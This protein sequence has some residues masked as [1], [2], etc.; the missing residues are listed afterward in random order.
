[1]VRCKA[2]TATGKQCSR[3]AA[4]G[5]F[6]KQH[7]KST[8]FS[9]KKSLAYRPST[10]I[11]Q[12]LLSVKVVLQPMEVVDIGKKFTE[13]IYDFKV[14]AKRA[15]QI[16]TNSLKYVKGLGTFTV[17]HKGISVIIHFDHLT[18]KNIKDLFNNYNIDKNL[19]WMDDN[20]NLEYYKVDKSA[21]KKYDP[22]LYLNI[23]RI[24]FFED[25][26][27]VKQMLPTGTSMCY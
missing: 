5:K 9:P 20:I 1:M 23:I 14:Q 12:K 6:C 27:L 25:Q 21:S 16:I 26:K 24:D 13:K 3:E 8:M 2:I 7:S 22:E 4:V 15:N 18:K 17:E 19:K 10:K 11:P